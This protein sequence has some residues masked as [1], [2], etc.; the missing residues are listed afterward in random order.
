MVEETGVSR[1]ALPVTADGVDAE[2]YAVWSDGRSAE[3]RRRP[4]LPPGDWRGAAGTHPHKGWLASAEAV[5]ACRRS[6]HGKC[7]CRYQ[8]KGVSGYK[9]G[10][11]R[12]RRAARVITEPAHGGRSLRRKPRR[13]A[14]SRN[15]TPAATD[16]GRRRT[17]SRGL[18]KAPH[19]HP[20]FAD[21]R[22]GISTGGRRAR[23]SR[24]IDRYRLA[25][26]VLD[27]ITAGLLS[28]GSSRRWHP[29]SRQV[30]RST[31]AGLLRKTYASTSGRPSPHHQDSGCSAPGRRILRRCC[32]RWR[33]W[34]GA[35]AS[36]Q[37]SSRGGREGMSG[38]PA[39][40][41]HHGGLVAQFRAA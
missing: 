20:W 25:Q 41:L 40:G 5:R 18:L 23:A 28:A 35:R 15:R 37:R 31:P 10:M 32:G 24:K 2:H 38:R 9:G 7:H 19:D 12:W 29:A 34:N 33:L 22:N 26:V 36:W 30:P 39:P 3:V 16:T 13:S 11:E 27:Q 14:P 1:S 4:G 17:S 6:A 8:T 21:G